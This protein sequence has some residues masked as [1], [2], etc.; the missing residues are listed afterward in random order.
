[1]MS[2][3]NCVL[4]ECLQEEQICQNIVCSIPIL[5]RFFRTGRSFSAKKVN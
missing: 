4:G 1:M 2:I 5:L 3:L